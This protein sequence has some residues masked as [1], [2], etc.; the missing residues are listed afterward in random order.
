MA[1]VS[2]EGV[3]TGAEGGEPTVFR[4]KRTGSAK[5]PLA[6]WYRVGGAATPGHDFVPPPGVAVFPAGAAAVDVVLPIIDDEEAEGSE[7]LNASVLP[8]PPALGP[9]KW[10]S[11]VYGW[12]KAKPPHVRAT[13]EG[14]G[15]GGRHTLLDLVRTYR[16]EGVPRVEFQIPEELQRL[17]RQSP[18]QPPPAQPPPA[19]PPPAHRGAPPVPPARVSNLCVLDVRGSERI[20]TLTE[21]TGWPWEAPDEPAYRLSCYALSPDEP[22]VTVLMA[23]PGGVMVRAFD[24]DPGDCDLETDEPDRARRAAAGV[25]Y[26]HS[27]RGSVLCGPVGQ[28]GATVALKAASL[29]ELA[30]NYPAEVDAFLRPMLLR[31][32]LYPATADLGAVFDLDVK[33]GPTTRNV[34]DALGGAE[35]PDRAARERASSRLRRLGELELARLAQLE[36]TGG[37]ELGPEEV[38]RVRQSLAASGWLRHPPIRHPDGAREVDVAFLLD[39]LA[40]THPQIRAAVKQTLEERTGRRIDFDPNA[41]EAERLGA[42]RRLRERL[43]T[44]KAGRGR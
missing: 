14:A 35:D 23:G 6:V 42:L 20:W 27:R 44:G 33:H 16:E 11:R 8:P 34:A 9:M 26:L 10:P 37:G 31:L 21:A 25:C 40:H 28:G 12:V 41:P 36:R 18:A 22:D 29:D 3:R 17:L 7:S 15:F 32:G 43:D 4:L 13:L 38:A 30:R 1:Q 2:I 24:L 5:S 39:A 19:R